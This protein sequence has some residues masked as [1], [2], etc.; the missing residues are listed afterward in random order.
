MSRRAEHS[1]ACVWVGANAGRRPQTAKEKTAGSENTA[2]R[3]FS[4]MEIPCPLQ[5]LSII[6]PNTIHGC[7]KLNLGRSG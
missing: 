2:V 7:K 4:K 5:T 6:L 3:N 1:A